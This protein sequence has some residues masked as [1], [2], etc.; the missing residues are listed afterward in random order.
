MRDQLGGLESVGYTIDRD[1]HSLWY[2]ISQK[3][4][5]KS[6]LNL[7]Q[8]GESFVDE[9]RYIKVLFLSVHFHLPVKGNILTDS[10]F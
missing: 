7:N 10:Y 2:S 5:F 9:N 8:N 6:T 1:D 4:S 3:K